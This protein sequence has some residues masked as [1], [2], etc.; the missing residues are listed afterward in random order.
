M[1]K[2]KLCEICKKYTSRL[3]L[4]SPKTCM[5]CYKK[6]KHYRYVSNYRRPQDK[7]FS[8][9]EIKNIVRRIE[10][11]P[12]C[13]NCYNNL[14]RPKKYCKNCN[15]LK[16]INANGLCKKC[17]KTPKTICSQC[18][19][20]EHIHKSP[21]LC[22]NCWY[23]WKR[24]TDENFLIVCRLRNRLRMALKHYLKTGE[25]YKT[26]EYINY[27]AVIEHIGKCP[28]NPKNYHIDHIRPISSFDLTNKQEIKKAF[29]PENHQWLTKTENLKKGKKYK[30]GE[31]NGIIQN[32]RC[33]NC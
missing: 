24:K 10:N 20:E 14:H 3:A 28:G 13:R 6:Q 8:C 23:I 17:Y 32:S 25:Y 2:N 5:S 15:E 29:A 9:N 21:N 22:K 12:Y 11:K 31:N 1:K 33:K 27:K 30:L 18:N 26:D 4:K 16:I 19:K 7:C